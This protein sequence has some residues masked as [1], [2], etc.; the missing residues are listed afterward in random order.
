MSRLTL[1][2]TPDERRTTRA[3]Y[4]LLKPKFHSRMWFWHPRSGEFRL[5]DKRN[6]LHTFYSAVRGDWHSCQRSKPDAVKDVTTTLAD[7]F[8]DDPRDTQN[9]LYVI[10]PELG[11][12]NDPMVVRQLMDFA[13]HSQ[14]DDR[15][16]AMIIF[17]GSLDTKLP[18]RLEPFFNIVD[19]SEPLDLE[20]IAA[21][22]TDIFG[23]LKLEAT[24]KE[25]EYF[26]EILSGRVTTDFEVDNIIAGA[27]IAAKEAWKKIDGDRPK[28]AV[29]ANGAVF[30]KHLRAALEARYGSDAS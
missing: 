23:K 14:E 4:D 17:V 18:A 27:V 25:V 12:F 26:T 24:P 1:I 15:W 2:R 21:R 19:D 29:F 9:F 20:S 6:T 3:F 22:V 30:D 10:D 7:F 11:W 16:I 28:F 8:L 5:K 13:N